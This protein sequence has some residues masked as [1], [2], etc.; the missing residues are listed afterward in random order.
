MYEMRLLVFSCFFLSPTRLD[1]PRGQGPGQ[2]SLCALGPHLLNEWT[3]EQ[4]AC[5]G[6][7]TLT[8]QGRACASTHTHSQ[9]L[10]LSRTDSLA[11]ALVLLAYIHSHPLTYSYIRWLTHRG[12]FHYLRSWSGP[13]AHCHFQVSPTWVPLRQVIPAVALVLCLLTPRPS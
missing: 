4:S 2:C 9:M 12:L 7:C 8:Q 10:T 1:T 5:S 13:L 6:P 11:R 3:N